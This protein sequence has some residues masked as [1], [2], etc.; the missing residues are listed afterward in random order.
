MRTL[1][2]A[3]AVRVTTA[4]VGVAVL[5][6]LATV[7]L[8]GPVIAQL[9]SLDL[10]LRT[11]GEWEPQYDRRSFA[12]A[13]GVRVI[14]VR[15]RFHTSE[16]PG[17]WFGSAYDDSFSVR[18]GGQSGN[19]VIDAHSMNELGLGAFNLLTGATAWRELS[20]RILP[21][22]VVTVELE[23]SNVWDNLF[24]SALQVDLI[25]QV[26]MEISEAGTKLFDIDESPD[27]PE[28]EPL[29]F[30]SARQPHP[31]FAGVTRIGGTVRVTGAP[32]DS[33]ADL[34]L[35]VLQGTAV[36]AT[37]Q[38]TDGLRPGCGPSPVEKEKWRSL[39]S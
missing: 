6:L 13:N 19:S 25:D 24:D 38:L 22:E 2:S 26:T 37:A 33:L 9:Q 11:A 8:S 35:E 34:S 15:Y 29:K 31:Y 4:A 30:L 20:L 14:T 21:N 23:V 5:I 1:I 12:A 17:G 32:T 7:P 39:P 16:V 28:Y 10:L 18:I 27:T 3:V 36:V